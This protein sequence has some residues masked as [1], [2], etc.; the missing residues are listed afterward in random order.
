MV[1]DLEVNH[2]GKTFSNTSSALNSN[3]GENKII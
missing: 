3:M 1:W 2:K